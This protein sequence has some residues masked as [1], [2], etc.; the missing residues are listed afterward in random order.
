MGHLLTEATKSKV[1]ITVNVVIPV[2]LLDIGLA[3]QSVYYLFLLVLGAIN[4]LPEDVQQETAISFCWPTTGSI[5]RFQA[6]GLCE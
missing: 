2:K 4:Y 6:I 5:P 3:K 1:S